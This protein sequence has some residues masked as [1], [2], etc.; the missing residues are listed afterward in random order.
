MSSKHY[1]M[2]YLILLPFSL[3]ELKWCIVYILR[4]LLVLVCY[5]IPIYL[6]VFRKTSLSVLMTETT[7]SFLNYGQTVSPLR[8]WI[9]MMRL[10]VWS[11]TSTFISPSTLGG[12]ILPHTYEHQSLHYFLAYI[13]FQSCCFWL[14]AVSCCFSMLRMLQMTFNLLSSKITTKWR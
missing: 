12:D 8:S 7:K 4:K 10:W 13:I 9:L 6:H 3:L 5:F 1:D 14:L 11:L 2:S